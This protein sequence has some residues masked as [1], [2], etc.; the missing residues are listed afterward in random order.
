MSTIDAAALA[1]WLQEHSDGDPADALSALAVVTAMLLNK[2]PIPARTRNS[3]VGFLDRAMKLPGN[4][5]EVIPDGAPVLPLNRHERRK[6]SRHATSDEIFPGTHGPIQSEVAEKMKATMHALKGAFGENFD[7]T[8]FVAERVPTAGRDLP[9]FN[10]ASTADRRDMYAVL[11]AWLQKNAA[12][13]S[14]LDKIEDAPPTE[15]HQ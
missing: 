10:Y 2:A 6:L 11:Q 8:L 12:I 5:F 3:Y 15:Q 7:L 13:A 14:T 1:R 9:R 4:F